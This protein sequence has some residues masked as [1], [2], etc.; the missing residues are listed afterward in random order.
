MLPL[1]ILFKLPIPTYLIKSLLLGERI[2]S[3]I[4]GLFRQSLKKVKSSV[5]AYRVKEM[6][7]L[8]GGNLLVEVPCAYVIAR[9]DKLVPKS[10]VNEF[11]RVISKLEIIDIDGPHFIAQA[12]PH[13]CASV[14]K[15]YAA[16]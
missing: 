5:L 3:S 11:K 15:K 2:C 7:R 12:M 14:V 13:E 10:H 8:K 9:N 1:T 4:I 16:I 6:S